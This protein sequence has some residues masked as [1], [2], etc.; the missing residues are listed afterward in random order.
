MSEE[1]TQ[2]EV[3]NLLKIIAEQT[4]PKVEEKSISSEKHEHWK[5]EDISDTCPECKAEKDKIGKS[6]VKNYAQENK[7]LEY[8]CVECGTYF[9]EKE[10]KCPEC[11]TTK[12]RK[13]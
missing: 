11:G 10:K 9:G 7:N 12:V 13:I 3:I 8:E 4:K 5:A 2:K 6:Y 1:Q